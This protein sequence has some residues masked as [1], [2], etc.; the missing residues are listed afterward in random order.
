MNRRLFL[1]QS[2]LAAAGFARSAE[3]GRGDMEGIID[4]QIY[5]GRHPFRESISAEPEKL[6]TKLKSKKV[7]RA[8]AG[9]FEALFQRDIAGVNA[10]LVAQCDG[11]PLFMVVGAVH[12]KMPD[13]RADIR[14]CAKEH[15]MK[16]IRLHPNYHGYDLEDADFLA[17]LKEATD[18]GLGVQIVAQMED[19]RTQ[20]PLAQ[21]KAV[22]L[23]PLA[24]VLKKVPEAKVMVLN[25]NRAMSMTALAGCRVTL[26]F[27][28]LEGV[29]SVA[30]LLK[31]WP[32]DQL[33]FG[34]YAPFFYWESAWLKMEES[35]LSAEQ[36]Q[37]ILRGN[38][39]SW[40]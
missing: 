31:D 19:E 40:L 2:T 18:L 37:R 29:G 3:D 12:P 36:R 9:S 16:V 14:R 6:A 38:A 23:R 32:V 1:S 15:G 21:A 33:V 22:D 5:L 28:M 13:W 17:L 25:A 8:W 34:S 7:I 30:N 20:H 39:E 11:H 35:E 10:R 24:E 27:A 26:D 4:T